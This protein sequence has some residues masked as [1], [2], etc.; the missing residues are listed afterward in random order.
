MA[1]DGQLLPLT[2]GKAPPRSDPQNQVSSKPW[3]TAQAITYSKRSDF[4]EKLYQQNWIDVDSI[5]NLKA[6]A[7]KRHV[8][9]AL[10]GFKH[11]WLHLKNRCRSQ[12]RFQ[13]CRETAFETNRLPTASAHEFACYMSRK[14]ALD[15]TEPQ[16]FRLTLVADFWIE[17]QNNSCR[18]CIGHCQ[19]SK[20][21]PPCFTALSSTG[22]TDQKGASVPCDVQG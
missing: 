21:P 12:A 4:F 10:Q 8:L 13:A 18:L 14:V 22:Q 2:G 1:H 20:R 6:W 15:W 19:L 17:C 5:V 11:S 7:D 3:R 16:E 9:P